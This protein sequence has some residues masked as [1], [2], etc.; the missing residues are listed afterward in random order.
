MREEMWAIRQ[1]GLSEEGTTGS[2]F[3]SL[4]SS[5]LSDAC[6]SRHW[7]ST[8][9]GSWCGG[10]FDGDLIYFRAWPYIY[11][12]ACIHC[13]DLPVCKVETHDSNNVRWCGQHVSTIHPSSSWMA[14]I[15]AGR[16]HVHLTRVTQ[17]CI[18]VLSSVVKWSRC[19]ASDGL[20]THWLVS[21]CRPR[22]RHTLTVL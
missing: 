22:R 20:F 3:I 2:P 18:G 21:M 10:E 15:H 14:V 13:S 7:C 9:L 16:S 5:C 11:A 17:A 19:E 12:A 8:D 6:S 1:S 4:C